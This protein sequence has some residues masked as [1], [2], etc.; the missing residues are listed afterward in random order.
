MK[1]LTA[2]P[3]NKEQQNIE[4]KNIFQAPNHRF[5][6]SVFRFQLLWIYSLTPDTRH[7]KPPQKLAFFTGIAIEL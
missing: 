1:K 3:Q 4:V 7:L 6:V 2:E 5:Q